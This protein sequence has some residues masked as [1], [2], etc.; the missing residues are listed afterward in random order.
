MTMTLGSTT[1]DYD[2]KADVLYLHVGDPT[3]A[4]D[5]D[6]SPE[7]HGLRFDRTGQLI[8]VT[9]VRARE[10]AGAGHPLV[11]TVPARLEIDPKDLAGAL[12]PS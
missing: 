7:G 6:E 5:F 12:A 3:D 1:V 8:G 10:L 11:V 2:A 9:V 4:V